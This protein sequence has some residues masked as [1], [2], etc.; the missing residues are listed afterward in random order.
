MLDVTEPTE[1]DLEIF[2]D[3]IDKVEELTREMQDNQA[4]QGDGQI[5]SE[6]KRKMYRQI[7]QIFP[8]NTA[9]KRESCA[10]LKNQYNISVFYK[11]MLL[12][13]KVLDKN[14]TIGS[15][16][17]ELNV[18]GVVSIRYSK[19]TFYAIMLLKK[20]SNIAIFNLILLCRVL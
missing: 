18:I 11:K 12:A 10:C 6:P 7:P 1:N 20:V 17:T 8:G 14:T 3:F 15:F 5:S 4:N 19:I 13:S 2:L 9:K 16:F